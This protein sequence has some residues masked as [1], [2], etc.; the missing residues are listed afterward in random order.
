MTKEDALNKSKIDR[1]F[2]KKEMEWKNDKDVVMAA[3][4]C[5][6]Q[7]LQ[8]VS[9][10]LRNDKEVVL[11]AI[12]HPNPNILKYVSNE[13]KDDKEVVMIGV[14]NGAALQYASNRLKDDKEVVLK[15]VKTNGNALK[16]AS[17]RLKDDEEIAE[18]AI[19]QYLLAFR[20]ASLNLRRNKELCLRIAQ[21]DISFVNLL[22]ADG[23]KEFRDIVK[24]A[25]TQF[26]LGCW[27]N[28]DWSL[29]LQVAHHPEYLPTKEQR[30]KGERSLPYVYQVY[31]ARKPYWEACDPNFLP[32]IFQIEYYLQSNKEEVR[33]I[34]EL[35][36]DEWLAKMEEQKLKNKVH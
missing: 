29:R 30:E 1:D 32:S 5:N 19:R 2:L 9:D 22:V 20:H 23:Y 13:L 10:E 25:G 16:Y 7:S 12:F 31:H 4:Q 14:K 17:S 21:K 15:A 35:R 8:Y 33:R 18:C 34:Y 3:I 24:N 6:G 26:L 36:K 11:Q 27:D 28:K